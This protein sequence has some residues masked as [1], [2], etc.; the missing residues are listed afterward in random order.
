MGAV[1][2]AIRGKVE[3]GVTKKRVRWGG[4]SA[5]CRGEVMGEVTGMPWGL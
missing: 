3:G 1:V 2:G 4:N 5:V